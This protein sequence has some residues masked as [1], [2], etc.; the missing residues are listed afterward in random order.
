[1]KMKVKRHCLPRIPGTVRD[2]AYA[3]IESE[4]KN[5]LRE[6]A[7]MH[8][9]SVSFVQNTILADALGVKVI[10]R[11]YDYSTITGRIKK[12]VR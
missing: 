5:G 6:L 8:N 10:R 4:I 3:A 2:K 1:M 7:E 9:C 12:T 11:Y